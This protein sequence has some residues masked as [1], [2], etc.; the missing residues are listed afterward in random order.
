MNLIRSIYTSIPRILKPVSIAVTILA[1]LASP[2]IQAHSLLTTCAETK[3]CCCCSGPESNSDQSQSP[4]DIKGTC[5][6]EMDKAE[7][8]AEIPLEAQINVEKQ[9]ETVVDHPSPVY[10][11]AD[12]HIPSENFHET[13]CAVRGVGPPIFIINSS[14]LI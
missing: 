11:I 10:V 1:I 9:H 7:S 2:V 12:I 13:A 3:T 8:P 5:G 4:D 14:F 6:C